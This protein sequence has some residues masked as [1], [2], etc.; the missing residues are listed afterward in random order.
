[1]DQKQLRFRESFTLIELLVVIAIIAILA[2]ML[3]PALTQAR[4]KATT[5]SCA[6]QLRQYGIVATFYS[7]TYDEWI[8]PTIA[9]PGV[10]GIGTFSGHWFM[11]LVELSSGGLRHF[12]NAAKDTFRSSFR[13]PAEPNS[14]SNVWSAGMAEY[15][16]THYQTNSR[17]TGRAAA[18][19]AD[20]A[21]FRKI[22]AVKQPSEVVF[23]ID[24]NMRDGVG[25]GQYTDMAYR[26]GGMLANVL[27]F[28]GNVAAKRM[29]EMNIPPYASSSFTR[30]YNQG[31][32][33]CMF[34]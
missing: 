1:M 30:G 10:T 14:F 26:H 20:K 34:P 16:F 33:A 25:A 6:N 12:G 13:C 3:L 2:S 18:S 5:I 28:G 27:Y 4:N 31:S 15:M 32:G 23:I 22:G 8:L 7:D 21:W 19:S 24:C 9:H 29:A 17:F 11:Q